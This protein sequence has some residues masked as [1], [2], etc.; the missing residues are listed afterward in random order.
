MAGSEMGELVCPHVPTEEVK[1]GQ[2]VD[3]HWSTLDS[4]MMAAGALF[5]GNYFGGEVAQLAEEIANGPNWAGAIG[6]T[7]PDDV[8][9]AMLVNDDG[10]FGLPNI[11]MYSDYCILAAMARRGVGSYS[12]PGL[13]TKIEYWFE[14]YFGSIS[15]PSGLSTGVPLFVR[16]NSIPILSA[17]PVYWPSTFTMHFPKFFF[18]IMH[19]NP[20][21]VEASH[22]YLLGTVRQGDC[23]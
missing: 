20:F 16:Y 23:S 1:P 18:K 13:N 11:A 15:A 2:E 19:S 12:P 22:N 4:A 7:S 5:A 10:S 21:Y 3:G 17:S 6:F 9:V 14:K 8:Q